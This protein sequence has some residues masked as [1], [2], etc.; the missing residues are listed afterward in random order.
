MK[1][2]L[3]LVLAVCMLMT[4]TVSA[5]AAAYRDVEGHW[6]Q[7]SIERWTGYDVVNGDTNGN[8]NPQNCMTRGQAAAVL[9]R[10]LKLTKKADISKFKDI[11]ADYALADAIAM[12]VHS[13]LMNGTSSNTMEPFGTI[14]RQQMIALVARAIGLHEESSINKAFT[15]YK[16]VSSVFRGLVNSMVNHGYIHGMTETTL[17]PLNNVTR[18]QVMKMLDNAIVEYVTEANSTVTMKQDGIVVVVADN[19]TVKGDFNGIVVTSA[20]NTSIDGK[21]DG[22]VVVYKDGVTVSLKNST[23]KVEVIAKD[24]NVKVE[25]AP[26]GTIVT[27]ADGIN[28]TT[29]NKGAYQISAGTSVV[30][31]SGVSAG[32]GGGGAGVGDSSSSSTYTVAVSGSAMGHSL[33]LTT[34]TG[35]TKTTTLS[36]IVDDMRATDATLIANTTANLTT[37]INNKLSDAGVAANTVMVKMNQVYTAGFDA[38][39][40]EA[41]AL[42]G[43]HL[44]DGQKEVLG[45]LWMNP[46]VYCSVEDDSGNLVVD[47]DAVF[48]QTADVLTKVKDLYNTSTDAER[49]KLKTMIEN[50]GFVTSDNEDAAIQILE[51]NNLSSVSGSVTFTINGTADADDLIAKANA[52]LDTPLTSA[53]EKAIKAVAGAYSVTVTITK[54]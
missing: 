13:G 22:S 38:K 34:G 14:T 36:A 12:C 37:T 42:L 47:V 5:S 24:E 28:G 4:L 53:M 26:D 50:N 39:V 15:D 44:T 35:Y 33:T 19:V 46:A 30:I 1:K 32:G 45:A 29:A 52:K 17:V 27:A 21:F 6:A 8:F 54:V 23:G 40:D 2:V 18:A 9:A 16:Q 41:E 51:D 31:G 3:S 11:P 49:A 25:N 7:S 43:G 48:A 20:D 10:L